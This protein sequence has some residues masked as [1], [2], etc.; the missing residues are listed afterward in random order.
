PEDVFLFTSDQTYPGTA[1]DATFITDGGRFRFGY[2]L[3]DDT[4]VQVICGDA[5]AAHL[6]IDATLGVTRTTALVPCVDD[7]HATAVSG[8]LATGVYDVTITP[9]DPA[10]VTVGDAQTLSQKIIQ[11]PNGLTDLGTLRLTVAAM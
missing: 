11:A 7:S 8:A 6:Q 10:G 5:H 1:G 9:V 4:G 3:V 2:E